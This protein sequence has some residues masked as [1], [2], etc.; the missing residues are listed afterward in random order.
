MAKQTLIENVF[1]GLKRIFASDV[2]VR[3]IGKNKF[4]V[5]DTYNTQAMGMLATNYLNHKYSAFFSTI[6]GG[7]GGYTQNYSGNSPIQRSLLFREYEL[8]DQDPIIASALD[9][10]A[11]ECLG[12]NTVIPLLNG[13]KI[14]IKTL[15]DTNRTNFWVYSIDDAGKFIADQCKYVKFNGKK[16][17]YRFTLEDG[18]QLESSENHL[19]LDSDT[20]V[21]KYTTDFVIGDGIVAKR[22]KISD[23]YLS[24]YEMLFENNKWQYTHRL[25]ANSV[26]ELQMQKDKYTNSDKPVIHHSS[27]NKLNN[28]PDSLKWMS[29]E[30]HK[31]LHT[32]GNSDRWKND[33]NYRAKMRIANSKSMTNRMKDPEFVKRVKDGKIKWMKTLSSDDRKRIYGRCGEQNGQFGKNK[34]IDNGNYNKFVNRIENIDISEYINSIK[35]KLTNKQLMTRFN[36][37]NDDVF[38]INRHLCKIFNA[39]ESKGL[40]SA[41]RNKE[42]C[43]ILPLH[44]LRSEID[45]LIKNKINPRRNINLIAK[46]YKLTAHQLLKY[47]NSFGYSTFDKFISTS[48]HKIVNI[49]Y[50]GEQ[51]AYD[52]VNVGHTHMYAVEANDGS[53]LYC[54]NSTVKN[55]NGMIV[56]IKSEDQEIKSILENLFYD[57]LNIDFN[58]LHWTRNLV[59]YGD[60]FLKLDLAEKI[61]IVRVV[62]ISPY[63]IERQEGLTEYN[64]YGVQYKIEGPILKGVYEDYEISHFRLLSD[65]NFLPYGKSMIEPARRIWKQ[66]TLMEDAMLIHRIIRAPQ[67]RMFK[68][69]IGNLSPDDAKFY[70]Q[71]VS[72][73]IKKVPYIDEQTGDYNL[74]Y[75]MQNLTEDFFIPTR[76]GADTTQI[77][78]L[79]GLEYNAIE[80]VEYLKNKMMSALRIPKAFLGFDEAI[81]SKCISPDTRIPLING[82]EKSAKELIVDFNSGIKNYV[83]SYDLENNKIAI[84]EIEWAGYTRLNTNVIRVWLDNEQ[85]LDVTPDHKFYTRDY[86][87]IN[88]E[89]LKEGQSLLP[90]YLG[91]NKLGYTTVYQPSTSKYELV[92]KI[93]KEQFN[94]LDSNGNVVHHK[95]FNK[96]NNY[97]DNLDG[98]M[99]FWE[100]RKFHQDNIQHTLNSSENIQKRI[101]DPIWLKG[102]SRGGKIG[103]N[104]SKYKLVEWIKEHGPYNIG[105]KNEISLTCKHCGSEFYAYKSNSDKSVCS[106]AC[107]DKYYIHDNNALYIKNKSIDELVDI[108]KKCKSFKHMEETTSKL[109]YGRT[110]IFRSLSEIGLTK[111]EFVDRYMPLAKKNRGFYNNL[112]KFKVYQPSY[113]ISELAIISN[114]CNSI[115]DICKNANISRIEFNKILNHFNITPIQFIQMHASHILNNRMVSSQLIKNHKV[116][117]VETLTEKIDTCD[118]TINKYHNFAT[119][120][121]V[122]IH[123]STLSQEDIRFARTVE[124]IQKIIAAELKNLAIVHLFLQGF[125]NEDLANFEL[126]LTSPSVIYEQEKLEIWKSRL[127][128]SAAM[129]EQKIFGSKIIY[130]KI[131]GLSETERNECKEDLVED[132]KFQY[133]LQQILEQGNDPSKTVLHVDDGGTVRGVDD[134][135]HT[136]VAGKELGGDKEG[137]GNPMGRP[138]ETKTKYGTDEHPLGRD[139][140][141]QTAMHKATDVDKPTTSKGG[142]MSSE[143]K[144]K[145]TSLSYK[146]GILKENSEILSGSIKQALND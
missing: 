24:G 142:P 134:P 111:I 76:G 29:R 20:N 124:R 25:I 59:K 15:F 36:L 119:S 1:K 53:K 51:D 82:I 87:E 32:F 56:A 104:K 100:H 91:K 109:G 26:N 138:K 121:G 88:A 46:K 22:T 95:D 45:V 52:L 60:M 118:I 30:E 9:L 21:I 66:L 75:N 7:Y 136:L 28:D 70:M 115:S 62:P 38:N 90:L 132:T 41:I 12:A 39:K 125:N 128:V 97:P 120:A 116:F 102:A 96:L 10:Y 71:K 143:A 79:P 144:R 78:T 58:L 8:M 140:L 64:P 107:A 5:I 4:K 57:I 86:K 105:F 54:H 114:T 135:T 73:Q 127:E 43:N 13:E 84:G 23:G 146:A 72:D 48:N 122:I 123:N 145:I 103:G 89:D 35:N 108:A 19:W 33:I 139:P 50:I 130:N 63:Y 65:S 137:E 61:G 49:E 68:I 99:T 110:V 74:Q 27:Y 131:F 47:V 101:N 106:K 11:E 37:L 42:L 16:N 85:Y 14:S 141:G 81:N 83:Y 117:K 98:T 77:D 133:R 126:T 80:D 2:T 67:K 3:R 40:I 94:I 17:M 93:V 18:T 69:D 55:E 113:T 129:Q 112:L 34:G 92:H 44:K 6:K 31:Y